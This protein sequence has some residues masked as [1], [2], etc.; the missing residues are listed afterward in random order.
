[1]T[2]VQSLSLELGVVPA[3]VER[4]SGLYRGFTSSMDKL[5]S[6]GKGDQ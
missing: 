5:G 3:L 4:V 1:M 2:R 6:Q